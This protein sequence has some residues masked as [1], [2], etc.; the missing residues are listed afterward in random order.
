M[1]ILLDSHALL[2]WM[3]DPSRLQPGARQAIA[4]PSNLVFVSAASVWELGLKVSKGKLRLPLDF[5]TLLQAQGIEPLAFTAAHAMAS[6]GL[7]PLHGDPF[8]RALVA[9]CRLESLTLAT[10]DTILGDYGIAVL[11]V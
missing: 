1:R 4:D 11:P 3:D 2:W 9:Q 7:P 8:D 10:R 5:H 6:T